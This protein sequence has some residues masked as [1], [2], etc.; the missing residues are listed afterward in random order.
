MPRAALASANA[1]P[2][3]RCATV[4]R[5]T[6]WR[7]APTCAPSRFCS[8]M[9]TWKPPLSTCICRSGTCRQLPI[10][11]MASLYP[12]PRTSAAA[13]NEKTKND[14]AHL[15]GG[16]HPSR[17]RRSL[18]GS[19]SIQLWL[20]AAQSLSRHSALS[21]RSARRPSRCLPDTAVIRPSR[22]TRAET[23]T[24]PSARHKPASA[25]WRRRERELLTTS[26]FHVV[27]TVPHEL[28]VLALENPRSFY[29][30]LFTATPKPRWRSPSIPNTGAVLPT[31]PL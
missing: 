26:Y 10:R 21:H 12:A 2:R 27:F 22:I 8:G 7:L 5:R 28:N 30:L 15:R 16:R 6:C 11:W 24:A 14:S 13:L 17:A 18:P 31:G 29:D 1:S 25:G 19:V 4:G 9:A 20:S 23:G 3:T